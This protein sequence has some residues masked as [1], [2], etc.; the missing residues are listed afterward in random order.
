MK[1]EW[2]LYGLAVGLAAVLGS[3]GMLAS[4]SPAS[5]EEH[6]IDVGD[7]QSGSS[8]GGG[9]R[10]GYG[11]TQPTALG[12]PGEEVHEETSGAKQP[13][14]IWITDMYGTLFWLIN[15]TRLWEVEAG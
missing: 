2:K 5:A 8:G 13:L 10:R 12:D 11:M 1:R 4:P 9:L 14:R 7:S 6:V 15:E 3:L